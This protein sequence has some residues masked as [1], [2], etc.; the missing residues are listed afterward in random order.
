MAN[1]P[2]I[3]TLEGQLRLLRR[4]LEKFRAEVG[5]RTSRPEH[6][7][8]IKVYE[9]KIEEMAARV[10]ALKRQVEEA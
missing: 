8:R 3:K 10:A 1:T 5:R 7:T 4:D 6:A 9:G 2:G